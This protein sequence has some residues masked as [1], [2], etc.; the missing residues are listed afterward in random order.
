MNSQA[1]R[2]RYTRRDLL[3]SVL[4]AGALACVGCDSLSSKWSGALPF[5]GSMLSPNR[6]IGHRLRIP[7]AERFP[8]KSDDIRR[9][10][11]CIIVG[12]GVAGL[13][14]GYE[15]LKSGIDDFLI[16][17][18]ES[19]PGG[20]SKSTQYNSD[21]FDS[22]RAPWG[23]HYLPLPGTHNEPLRS[24]LEDSGVL[25]QNGE[26][27]EQM[28][29]RDPEERVWANGQWQY[30]LLPLS[31]ATSQDISQIERFQKEMSAYAQQT[32]AT[33]KP[34][35]V[36]PTS[37]ASDDPECLSLDQ[38]S[39]TQWMQSREFNSPRLLWLV[40]HSC[41]DDYG[42]RAE[43]TSAWAGIFYFA[44]RLL[45]PSSSAESAPVLTWPEGNGFL[46]DQ[47][48]QRVGNRI[49]KNQA[50]LSIRLNEDG[51]HTLHSFDTQTQK[52]VNFTADSVILA[53]P[54]FIASQLLPDSLGEIKKKRIEAAR[55]FQ[56]GSWLVANVVLKDRPKETQPAMCW[57]NVRYQS[58]SLGYV[59]AGHQTGR[60]H[61]GTVLTWYQALTTD[62][63]AITRTELLNLTWQEAAEVVCSDLEVMHADIRNQIETLDLMVWGHA[64]IQPIVGSR[65]NPMWARASESIGNIHFAASDLSGVA[66][67][68]E[69]FDHG[70]RAAQA[71]AQSKVRRK[72][73]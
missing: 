35:F 1:R 50:V 2:L 70:R 13:S 45:N 53:V 67:F 52:Q 56:Y 14:A 38:L 39:M 68:E 17:E 46:I 3:S 12:G 58:D 55:S 37:Q 29:C 5:S 8:S 36:L 15:L 33:G 4:G 62:D 48:A 41:R 26:P 16:L 7:V 30:G 20:T 9:H 59:N 61:G 10:A 51:V 63:A 66:L 54:Q 34:W 22:L 71:V 60:D 44:S 32:D 11:S 65:S 23:A 27:A 21:S 24:F 73:T 43:Q 28:L 31:D 18:L 72:S 64:M 25:D 69:A 40:D 49:E 6:E 57:D 19:S 47:L 42:L